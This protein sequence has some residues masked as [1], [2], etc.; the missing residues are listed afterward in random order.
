MIFFCFVVFIHGYVV[1]NTPVVIILNAYQSMNILIDF[2]FSLFYNFY[3]L[4]ICWMTHVDVYV[5]SIVENRFKLFAI[6]NPIFIKILLCD[7]TKIHHPF[8]YF[9]LMDLSRQNHIFILSPL[10]NQ[11]V[12][13]HDN[14]ADDRRRLWM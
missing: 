14:V 6:Y 10:T 13:T 3:L 8:I 4:S 2:Y 9:I 5:Q 12:K 11:R 7:K 1:D